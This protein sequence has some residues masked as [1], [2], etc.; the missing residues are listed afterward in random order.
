[1]KIT[2]EIKRVSGGRGYIHVQMEENCD[3]HREE[4]VVASAVMTRVQAVLD[5]LF[6]VVSP[7]PNPSVWSESQR[8]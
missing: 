3:A 2:I 4:K 1:M 5:G 8:N 6:E 7:N